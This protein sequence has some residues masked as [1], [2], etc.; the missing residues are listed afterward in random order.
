MP[1]FDKATLAERRRRSAAAMDA[2]LKSDDLVLFFSGDPIQ[3][4]GG[5]DQTYHFLPHPDYFWLSGIRRPWGATTYSK[6]DGWREFIRP[7]SETE[8][9]WEGT[10]ETLVG[11][12]I[13]G[14]KATLKN[15]RRIFALG[16][17]NGDQ[18]M[19]ATADPQDVPI[20]QESVNSA[21]RIKDAAEIQLIRDIAHMANAGYRKLRNFIRSGV[22]ERQIQ[23]EYETEVL[24]AG[25]EKFPYDMIVGS[26]VNSATLHALPT[27][28]IVQ[29]GDL[30]LIDAGAD[31][32]DYCV[33]I[34][35]VFSATGTFSSRQ[36]DIYKLVKAAQ[37]AAIRAALPG[38]EW[39]AVHRASAKVIAEGLKALNLMS[40]DVDDLLDSG[41]VAVF[42]P[43]GVGH[44][45]GLR[46]RD[47]GPDLTKPMNMS[48]G[49][50]L[51]TDFSLQDGFVMTAEPGVYFV[52]AL[53]DQKERREKFRDQIRWSEVDKW[54]DFGG[55][56]IE[57]DILIRS[58]GAEVLTDVVEK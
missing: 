24:K 32:H 43:H 15:R 38:V 17:P 4:P 49:V 21:R 46:V 22:T 8:R 14:L 29:D 35:R 1:I 44:M 16:Q 41:A 23:I 25:A 27:A 53:L 45:V 52:P 56:R 12:D 58:G 2:H 50:R 47:V 26:G 34:T 19:W 13:V 42:F 5:L 37:E 39:H 51:R 55:I 57:D 48:C 36:K 18:K 9:L 33:D 20:L 10:G 54:R 6:T 40:G 28:R 11:E 31:V 3:K 7:V 30:I